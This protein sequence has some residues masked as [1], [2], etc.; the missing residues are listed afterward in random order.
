MSPLKKKLNPELEVLGFLLTKYDSRKTMNRNV[1]DHLTEE[2]GEKVFNTFIRTNIALATAQEN[3]VD[4]FTYDKSS[5]GAKD[6]A[7]L[8]EEFLKRIGKK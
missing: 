1:L 6:Y 7:Q 3:G 2:Y 8:A 4:I 5:N